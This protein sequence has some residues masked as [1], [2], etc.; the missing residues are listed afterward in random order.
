MGT[1]WLKDSGLAD[2]LIP[3][4]RGPVGMELRLPV[5]VEIVGKGE[6]EREGLNK[7]GSAVDLLLINTPNLGVDVPLLNPLNVGVVN[8]CDGGSPERKK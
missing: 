8:C 1:G 6:A 4:D 2:K 7:E 5:E 3:V